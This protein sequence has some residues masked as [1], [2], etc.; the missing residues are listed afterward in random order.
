MGVLTTDPYMSEH[1][2]GSICIVGINVST[3]GQEG[4]AKPMVCFRIRPNGSFMGFP[5][6][7]LLFLSFFH[8]VNNSINTETL[9]VSV[10]MDLSYLTEQIPMYERR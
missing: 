8:Y 6:S 5:L 10:Y 9:V 2:G 3:T 1:L 7:Y 4:H